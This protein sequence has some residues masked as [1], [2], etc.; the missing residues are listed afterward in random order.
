MH[1]QLTGN[2]VVVGAGLAGL[3]VA[4]RVA[5]SGRSVIVLEKGTDDAYLCN[6]RYTGG[7]FHIAMDDM[8]GER[9]WMLQNVVTATYGRTDVGLAQA[10]VDTAPRTLKWLRAQGI[11]FIKAGPDGLRKH[12]LAPPGIRQTGLNPGGRPYWVGR[13]GDVMLRNL[14]QRLAAFG[15]TVKRGVRARRLLMEERRCVGVEAEFSGKII[16]IRARAVALADGGF[17]ANQDLMRR[18]ISPKPERLMQRNART[19]GGDALLM[20]EAIGAKLVGTESFYG[21]L[22]YR[23]AINDDRFWPY[24][25]LDSLVSGGLVVNASGRRFCDE[26][27]GGIYVANMIARLDDPLSATVVFDSAIWNEGPARDFL[28]PA[29]PNFLK[30][31]GTFCTADTVG[32]LA[33]RIGV[34]PIALEETVEAHNRVAAGQLPNAD[35]VPRTTTK[36]RSWPIAK[37]PFLAIPLC[38]GVTYTM[39]GIATDPDG[40]VLSN[41]NGPISGLFAA[42]ACTGGLEGWNNAGYSGGLS[43]SSVFGMRA[44]ECIIGAL[45]GP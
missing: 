29:N 24:P 42:G 2:L 5:Q 33:T 23:N 36:Y 7:L 37:T 10:L 40:R 8:A 27:R 26:G 43:K 34:D 19:S 11:R 12:A 41:G 32:E 1:D 16:H 13:S 30:A 38:A 22:L 17:Q 31:G 44:G 15:G 4:L 35:I 9:D 45:Q 6:S 20:A 25:L 21:H 18:F 28:L 39:G 3:A 14:G